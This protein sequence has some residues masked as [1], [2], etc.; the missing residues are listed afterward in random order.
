MSVL[1]DW[2]T[3]KRR[4]AARNLTR[5]ADQ[6][7][8][9]DAVQVV[10]NAEAVEREQQRRRDKATALRGARATTDAR[11]WRS[12]QFASQQQAQKNRNIPAR[13]RRRGDAV[14][15]IAHE[16]T[17]N[18]F[19]NYIVPAGRSVYDGSSSALTQ[20]KDTMTAMPENIRSVRQRVDAAVADVGAV[21]S[22]RVDAAQ[23]DLAMIDGDQRERWAH[24]ANA[25]TDTRDVASHVLSQKLADQG[26]NA[27]EMADA[28][29]N[30]LLYA[31][32]DTVRRIGAVTGASRVV[33]NKFN[34]MLFNTGYTQARA[35]A[36]PV[37]EEYASAAAS[38]L[39]S[40]AATAITKGGSLA[41]RGLAAVPSL[42]VSAMQR[43]DGYQNLYPQ[44][45]LIRYPSELNNF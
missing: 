28:L 8:R 10:V 18:M 21:V 1:T 24:D 22:A 3:Q 34:T 30:K 4:D 39:G 5:M 45:R 32:I 31:P 40:A 44:Q 43:G 9:I 33:E 42:L 23:I 6:Q 12:N 37:L 11:R 17:T 36:M 16:F 14:S 19:P 15:D 35:N 25:R 27:L 7:D 38:A 2:Q 26:A 20:S 41:L 29:E 13:K